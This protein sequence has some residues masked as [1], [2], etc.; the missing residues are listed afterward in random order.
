MTFHPASALRPADRTI[1]AADG[2]VLFHRDWGTGRPVVFLAGWALNSRMWS[3][4]MLRLAECGA[5][6]VAFDRRGHGRSADPGRGYDYDT[7]ADD[8]AAVLDALDLRDAVLVGHSMAGGEIVRCLTRHG[9]VRVRGIVL[10]SPTPPFPLQT[11][12]N[13]GGYERAIF[14]RLRD[15]VIDD[16]PGWL[17]ANARPFFTPDTGAGTVAWVKAMMAESTLHA[18]AGCFDAM[19]ETDFRAELA[20]LDLPALVIH[21]DRDASAP[22]EIT[23]AP[24]AALLP[25]GRLVV[26]EGAP[27]GL[28]VTDAAR[29]QQDLE[30]FVLP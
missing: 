1:V 23:G 10:L 9:R 3:R 13:P 26:Y 2:T 20:R 4:A 22:L 7:L 12:D 6:T 18:L 25:R 21:G 14:D 17:D 27:H 28:F 15:A 19:V 11:P 24:T 30:A 16:F 5:R 29:L 8:L